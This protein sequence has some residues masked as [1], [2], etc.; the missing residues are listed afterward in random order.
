[1]TVTQRLAPGLQEV[2]AS[3]SDALTIGEGAALN[4]GSARY[5]NEPAGMTVIGSADGSVDKAA[6]GSAFGIADFGSWT[7]LSGGGAANVSVVN[8]AGNPTGSG[9]AVRLTW[10]SAQR[11]AAVADMILSG[12][13]WAEIY[14]VHRIV[15]PAGWPNF[16]HKWFYVLPVGEDTPGNCVWTSQESS[17]ALRVIDG[18]DNVEINAANALAARDTELSI[19]YHFVAESAPAANNGQVSVWV[20]DALVGFSAGVRMAAGAAYTA[21]WRRIH[22]YAHA[23]VVPSDTYFD[24]REFYVS[25]K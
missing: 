7:G 6:D 25:G 20:N 8:D 22:Y 5:P 16:G 10:V 3:D 1:M 9:K 23:N 19:E 13:P 14:I 15:I 2:I 12:G 17:N 21:T 24:V 4:Q 11:E 18:T